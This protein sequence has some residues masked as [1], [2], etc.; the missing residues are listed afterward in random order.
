MVSC[1]KC[2][3]FKGWDAPRKSGGQGVCY[4]AIA[5]EITIIRNIESTSCNSFEQKDNECSELKE[6]LKQAIRAIEEGLYND[7]ISGETFTQTFG[8]AFVNYLKNG[9]A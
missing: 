8:I 4:K 1:E 3:H 2:G 5:G 9:R 6:R 7:T